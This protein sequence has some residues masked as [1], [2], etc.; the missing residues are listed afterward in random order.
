MDGQI[1]FSYSRRDGD[2]VDQL[3]GDLESRGIDVWIDRG[4]IFAGD[5]TW[6]QQIVEAIK[7]CSVF[8]IVLSPNSFGSNNV[9][10]ELTLA[11]RHNKTIIPIFYKSAEIPNSMAYQ[12]AGLQQLDFSTGDYD[13]NLLSLLNALTR[14]GFSIREIRR[15]G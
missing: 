12:L 10:R 11:E 14:L 1:F 8:F 7:S 13:E 6:R 4:D 15:I 5:T 9:N 3:S 2:F